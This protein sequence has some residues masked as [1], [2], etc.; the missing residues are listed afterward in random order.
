HDPVPTHLGLS[1][2]TYQLGYFNILPLY[3]VLMAA[4]IVFAIID[5]CAPN[6]LL[7]LSVL[8]YLVTLWAPVP[9]PTWPLQ[10]Q[11]FFNPLAW[12]LVFGLGFGLAREDGAGGFVRRHI[13][14][15][16]WLS[17]PV[18]VAGALMVWNGWWADPETIP[19][20]RLFFV[21]DKT[22]A[23]PPRLVQ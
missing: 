19:Q 2:L 16:R 8:V 11:W 18:L 10:G 7:P 14:T 15:I 5:R 1:L 21:S 17:L 4:A 6:A 20:P 9:T 3:V 13:V 22:Y 23:T 12:Q